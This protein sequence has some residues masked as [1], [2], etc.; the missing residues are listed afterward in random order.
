MRPHM[1]G[2]ALLYK[3]SVGR[4]FLAEPVKIYKKYDSCLAYR[5][6]LFLDCPKYVPVKV[7]VVVESFE[8]V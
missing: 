4:P 1:K 8:E 5:K 7:K 2:W 6:E 3:S